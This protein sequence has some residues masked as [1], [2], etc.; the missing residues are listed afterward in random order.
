MIYPLVGNCF[1]SYVKIIC[2]KNNK[3]N[4]E[5]KVFIMD[6]RKKITKSLW[7]NLT[8]C[9]LYPD[10]RT[11]QVLYRMLVSIE[12]PYKKHQPSI[13]NSYLFHNTVFN[14]RTD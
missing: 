14:R 7:I 11:K 6:I 13:L 1:N 3:Y 2:S 10:R 8:I 5:G 12:N 9:L 4:I